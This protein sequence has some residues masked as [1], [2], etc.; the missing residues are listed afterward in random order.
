MCE[1]RIQQD[2]IARMKQKKSMLW[3]ENVP[4]INVEQTKSN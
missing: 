3:K 1:I 2:F 4:K